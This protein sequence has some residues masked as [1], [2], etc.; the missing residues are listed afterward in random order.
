M[1]FSCNASAQK[2]Y[3]CCLQEGVETHLD[4]PKT[5][6]DRYRGRDHAS[7][8]KQVVERPPEGLRSDGSSTAPRRFQENY[9]EIERSLRLWRLGAV[10]TTSV[11]GV[12][13]FKGL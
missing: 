4:M 3:E 9:T 5:L 11:P 1:K 8:N 12:K 6:Q 10:D 7:F 13:Q 2:Y